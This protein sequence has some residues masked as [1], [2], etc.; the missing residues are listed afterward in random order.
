VA[1]DEILSLRQGP[2]VELWPLERF[3]DLLANAASLAPILCAFLNQPEGGVLLVG[4]R[5][6]G[7]VRGIALDRSQRDCIRQV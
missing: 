7:L 4:V 5:R 1:R 3:K 2:G 6:D